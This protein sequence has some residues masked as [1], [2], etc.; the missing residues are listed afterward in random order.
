[1]LL[2]FPRDD[3]SIDFIKKIGAFNKSKNY[4]KCPDAVFGIKKI[5][6][7]SIK[8]KNM[9]FNCCNIIVQKKV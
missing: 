3:S 8:R 7:T 4:P 6:R 5:N 2:F 9:S 1:M